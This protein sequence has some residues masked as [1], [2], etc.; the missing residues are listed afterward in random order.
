MREGGGEGFV[1]RIG[2]TAGF[3]GVPAGQ[4]E[5][6]CA[7]DPAAE[8]KVDMG[9]VKGGASHEPVRAIGEDA[10]FEGVSGHFYRSLF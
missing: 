3:E 7:D 4:I 5:E 1:G 9:V 10:T 8:L 2:T 6:G